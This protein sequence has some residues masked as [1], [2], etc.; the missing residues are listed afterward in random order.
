[1]AGEAQGP[2]KSLVLVCVP[3]VTLWL[4]TA[5]YA[6][7]RTPARRGAAIRRWKDRRAPLLNRRTEDD[8]VDLSR[9]A[10]AYW[11]GQRVGAAVRAIAYLTLVTAAVTQADL[12]I[13]VLALIAA[14]WTLGQ[15]QKVANLGFFQVAADHFAGFSLAAMRYLFPGHRRG[16]VRYLVKAGPG[17]LLTIAG[18]VSILGAGVPLAA[19]SGTLALGIPGLYSQ[20]TSLP[21]WAVSAIGFAIGLTLYVAGTRAERSTKRRLM[22]RETKP[23]RWRPKGQQMVFLRPFGSEEL[24]VSAHA[25]PR[26]DGIGML[27]PRRTEF[28]EDV[29]TWLLW[30]RGEV[31]AVARP[32][33]G[34]LRTVGA[35]HHGVKAGRDWTEAVGD[36]LRRATGIVMVPGTSPGVAW[37]FEQV[38]A[39]PGYAR[40]ALVVNPE[41]AEPRP[42]L[43]LVGGSGRQ[44][45]TLRERGL[46]PVAAILR[47][48]GPPKLLCAPLAEDIDFEV[49]VEWF[50]TKELP[51][52]PGTGRLAT[53]AKRL[54]K[55]A[56]SSGS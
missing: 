33:A 54:L 9:R 26:R 22:R 31:V 41:P 24:R 15:W 29:L 39:N 27:M 18:M 4:A 16:V 8:V 47:T 14:I 28:L 10:A 23:S 19:G 25:G 37:E 13:A 32:G 43:A 7:M 52:P 2:L 12:I 1:V 5:A 45:A 51:D 48:G 11:I 55:A 34:R 6:W 50:L 56:G 35:A 21:Y 3:T 42:F 49:A 38:R 36:L 46:L 20:P 30:S 53:L 17:L 44:E 40:K